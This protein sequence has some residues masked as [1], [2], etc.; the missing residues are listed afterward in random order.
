MSMHRIAQYLKL[1][2]AF[3]GKQDEQRWFAV[4]ERNF[5]VRYQLWQSDGDRVELFE[6]ASRNRARNG[7]M[8][9]FML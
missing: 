2:G 4:P 1:N 6:A 5:K 7:L 9:R 8:S 3:D